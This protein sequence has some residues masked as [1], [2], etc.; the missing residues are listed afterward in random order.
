[1]HGPVV[2]QRQDRA[3]DVAAPDAVASATESAAASHLVPS[4]SVTASLSVHRSSS[5]SIMN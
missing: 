2:E 3:A 4:V 5:R 1:V